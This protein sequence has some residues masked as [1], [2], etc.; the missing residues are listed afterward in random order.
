M[1]RSEEAARANVYCRHRGWQHLLHL[2]TPWT[3]YVQLK[4]QIFNSP[5]PVCSRFANT[6]PWYNSC[7][8]LPQNTAEKRNYPRIIC[9]CVLFKPNKPLDLTC[10]NCPLLGS[11]WTVKYYHSFKITSKCKHSLEKSFC[12]CKM[13]CNP[14][15]HKH[16]LLC[17]SV[18]SD[19]TD[20]NT[21]GP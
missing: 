19:V 1:G 3:L 16:M 18:M 10:I 17:Y 6:V 8:D 4:A 20:S 21:A 14:A 15:F 9:L 11:V 5:S 13:R 7:L 2:S 12:S